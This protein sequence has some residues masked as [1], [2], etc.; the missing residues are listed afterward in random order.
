MAHG[1]LGATHNLDPLEVLP[2][3][4]KAGSTRTATARASKHLISHVI[5]PVQ[6]P[7][8]AKV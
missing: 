3:D 5:P 4:H 6:E 7:L 8:Y 2:Q 1:A